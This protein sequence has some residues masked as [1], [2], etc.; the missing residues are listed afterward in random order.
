MVFTNDENFEISYICYENKLFSIKYHLYIQDFG[1]ISR[2]FSIFHLWFSQKY[3]KI[4][5]LNVTHT[6]IVIDISKKTE[7]LT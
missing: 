6:H 5:R 4:C 1:D 3:E 7:R 2:S